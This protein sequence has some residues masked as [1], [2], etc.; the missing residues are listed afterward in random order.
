MDSDGCVW[1]G[2][3][4]EL[5]RA[6]RHNPLPT[7]IGGDFNILRI[8]MEK[9]NGTLKVLAEENLNT[10]EAYR[11]MNLFCYFLKKKLRFGSS[12]LHHFFP[13]C[14]PNIFGSL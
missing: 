11:F 1:R 6:C 3:L 4:T 8:S 10:L 5:V 14:D 9:N 12:M 7:L 2:F 13:F